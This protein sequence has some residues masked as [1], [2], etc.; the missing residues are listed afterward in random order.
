LISKKEILITEISINPIISMKAQQNLGY[1]LN[2]TLGF[3][4]LRIHAQFPRHLQY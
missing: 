3:Q 2:E 1:R 4:K